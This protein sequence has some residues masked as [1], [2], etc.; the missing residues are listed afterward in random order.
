MPLQSADSRSGADQQISHLQS[1][2]EHTTLDILAQQTGGRAVYDSNALQ[3]AMADA[4]SDGSNFYTLAYVPTNKDFDG[5]QRNIQVRLAHG[6][7]DLFYRRSYYA[8]AA[9]LSQNGVKQDSQTVFLA[10]ME[11]GVPADSQVLFNVHVAAADQQPVTGSL[12]GANTAL[13]NPAARYAIGYTADLGT[14]GLAQNSSGAWQGHVEALAIAYDHD[15]KRLNWTTNDVPIALDQAAREADSRDGLAIHQVL[16]LP[17][18]EV[19]L[20]VG[21]YDRSSGRFGS[22][23]IPLH[24]AAIK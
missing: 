7:A 12:A 1:L 18:G 20:R 2:A 9:M 5:A 23:E 17:A 13:K 22:L 14:I 16:D 3:Q 10:S 19:Y 11:R 24:V 15:G 21:L 6:K 8:D 4:L